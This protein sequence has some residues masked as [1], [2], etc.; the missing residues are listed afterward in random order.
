M[1]PIRWRRRGWPR[2]NPGSSRVTDLC[3]RYRP[4]A[5]AGTSSYGYPNTDTFTNPDVYSNAGTNTGAYD[6]SHSYPYT[7]PGPHAHTGA[8][9]HRNA[10][11]DPGADG[12]AR[13]G[14]NAGAHANGATPASGPEPVTAEITTVSFVGTGYTLYLRTDS[15]P[16]GR[17]HERVTLVVRHADGTVQKKTTYLLQMNDGDYTGAVTVDRERVENDD[18]QWV[19]KNIEVTVIPE[20]ESTRRPANTPAPT[21]SQRAHADTRANTRPRRRGSACPHP[22]EQTHPR[23]HES[24]QPPPA[25]EYSQRR[26][27]SKRSGSCCSSSTRSG[28]RREYPR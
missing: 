10:R 13:A 14:S 25:Q 9:P 1:V 2:G 11:A 3:A 18:P 8:R 15:L 24:T 26:A 20:P 21:R 19:R 5:D 27:T 12:N 17:S 22:H 16:G 28:G 6:C 4:N 7:G 23:R